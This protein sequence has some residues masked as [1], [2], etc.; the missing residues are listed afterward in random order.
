MFNIYKYL[1]AGGFVL[2]DALA[3][4]RGRRASIV[5]RVAAVLIFTAPLFSLNLAVEQLV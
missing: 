4:P 3:K 1:V 2:L 5:T